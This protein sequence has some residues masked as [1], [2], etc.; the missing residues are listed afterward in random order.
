VSQY[1]LRASLQEFIE[2]FHNPAH[3]VQEV[4]RRVGQ[5]WGKP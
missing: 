1:F 5:P 2:A 4:I 3:M